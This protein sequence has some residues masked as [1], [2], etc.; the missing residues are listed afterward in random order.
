MS[1]TG[2]L[3]VLWPW[4]SV[5]SIYNESRLLDQLCDAF[6]ETWDHFPDAGG[7]SP[8]PPKRA[9]TIISTRTWSPPTWKYEFLEKFS[10]IWHETWNISLF[11]RILIFI[12]SVHYFIVWKHTF[13]I[14]ERRLINFVCSSPPWIHIKTRPFVVMWVRFEKKSWCICNKN[15]LN[16][17][18][19]PKSFQ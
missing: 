14:L 2:L 11:I 10:I 4:S 13:L 6:R 3:F 1:S 12:Y 16:K 7:F 15:T 17:M 5:Y 19:I 8:E 18:Y 9:H